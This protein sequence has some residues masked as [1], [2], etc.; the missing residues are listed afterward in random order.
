MKSTDEA[1]D[2][3]GFDQD[4][5]NGLYLGTIAIVFLGNAKWKQG[6]GREE[7]AEP[8]QM[9]FVEKTAEL[10]ELESEFFCDTFMKPKLKV[11]KDYVKKGQ[12]L[13]QVS[14]SI[15]ATAK[16]LFSRMF[17]WIVAKVNQ[18]LDTPNPRKNFIG[19]GCH[20]QAD[21]S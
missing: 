16:S 18:S 6:K 14:F 21:L 15:S 7:Q 1:F 9:E 17:D 11:G 10:L 8:D 4:E 12:N 2:I 3:L 20:S 13:D 19:G 5:K